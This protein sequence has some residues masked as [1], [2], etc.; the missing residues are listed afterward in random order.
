MTPVKITVQRYF[1]R[2]GPDVAASKIA[3]QIGSKR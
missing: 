1:D 2:Y 3:V